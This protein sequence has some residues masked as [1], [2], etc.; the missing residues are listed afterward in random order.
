MDKVSWGNGPYPEFANVKW[1]LRHILAPKSG[2]AVFHSPL[3]ILSFGPVLS[4]PAGKQFYKTASLP[5]WQYRSET[6]TM[7]FSRALPE[8][9][10]LRSTF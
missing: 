2:A 3:D 6:N 7:I 1:L 4:V 10:L 9:G 5:D 8:P